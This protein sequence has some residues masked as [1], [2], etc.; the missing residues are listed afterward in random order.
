LKKQSSEALAYPAR[1]EQDGPKD[2]SIVFPNVPEAVTGGVTHEEA[3]ANAAE[4]LALALSS[5]PSRGL[6]FPSTQAARKGERLVAVPATMAAKLFIRRAMT[7]QDLS[8]ADL[9]RILK[10]DHKSV[11]RILSLSHRTRMDD[12]EAVLARLGM[13]VALMAA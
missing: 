11:R 10:T 1:I 2:F 6:P 4:A 13:Q 3:W 7:E 12:L 9:A 8:P 5:Y